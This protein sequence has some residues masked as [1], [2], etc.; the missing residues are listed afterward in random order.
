MNVGGGGG[1]VVVLHLDVDRI[2]WDFSEKRDSKDSFCEWF[3]VIIPVNCLS[4]HLEDGAHLLLVLRL[5][6]VVILD[7]HVLM[8]AILPLAVTA[9][10]HTVDALQLRVLSVEPGHRNPLRCRM[11]TI[12]GHLQGR[13]RLTNVIVN[14]AQVEE[15]SI[16]LTQ[17]LRLLG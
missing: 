16:H 17:H 2:Q 11:D 15:V 9:R 4:A 12:D 13:N 10:F 6:W 3:V 7:Q 14:N 8:V 1:M 5:V